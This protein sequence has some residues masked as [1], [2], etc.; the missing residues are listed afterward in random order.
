MSD[1]P[2]PEFDRPPA[3]EVPPIVMN[4]VRYQQ[5]LGGGSDPQVGG[6]LAAYDITTG[7]ELWTLAV[8]DNKRNDD[9]EGDVQDI[10]FASM[11]IG[12]DGRLLIVDEVGRRF[13]VDVKAKTSTPLP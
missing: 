6:L 10:F 13:A 8:Y 7:Q 12:G 5:K 4:G 2:L 3:P 1:L 11:T 9:V